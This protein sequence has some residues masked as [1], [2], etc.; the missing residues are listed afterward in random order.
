MPFRPLPRRSIA[1]AAFVLFL[2]VPAIAQ[3]ALEPQDTASLDQ[4]VLAVA[5]ESDP[6]HPLLSKTRLA[7]IAP[8]VKRSAWAKLHPQVRRTLAEVERKFGRPVEVTSGCRSRQANRLAG[9]ARRSLHLDC[10]A[11]DF[12]VAGISKTKLVK[13][14]R[15]LPGRGGVGTY[16]RNSIVHVDAG[17]VRDWH[18]RCS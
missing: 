18:Q 5:S 15:S 8:P 16:C 12:K 6:A 4:K 7:S 3:S 2:A 10:M 14:V 11:A 1:A 17:P 9:G 13:F